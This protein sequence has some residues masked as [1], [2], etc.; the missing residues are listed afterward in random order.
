VGGAFGAF[1]GTFHK[2]LCAL[3]GLGAGT[4]LGVTVFAILPE[5]YEGLRWWGLLL[6]L[7]SGYGVFAFIS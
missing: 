3:I 7:G 6:A 2:R 5:S 1:F 4:P